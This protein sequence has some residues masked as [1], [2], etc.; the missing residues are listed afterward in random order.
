MDVLHELDALVTWQGGFDYYFAHQEEPAVWDQA[1]SDLRKIGL[2]DAAELFGVARDLFLGTDHFTEDQPAVNRYLAEMRELN[3]P[4][5]RLRA[6]PAPGVSALAERAW[7]GGVRPGGM[8]DWLAPPV[9]SMLC[10]HIETAR[11]RHKASLLHD[12]FANVLLT[13]RTHLMCDSCGPTHG[14]ST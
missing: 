2:S 1:Q 9:A 14:G 8:V 5:A 7:A 3:I 13:S 6:R 12:R 11:Q 4:L 10:L